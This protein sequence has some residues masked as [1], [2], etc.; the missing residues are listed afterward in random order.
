[1]EIDKAI[2]GRRSIRGY[3]DRDIP[4]SAMTEWLSVAIYAPSSMNGQPWCFIVVRAEKKK[5]HLVEIK[6]PYCA[7]EKQ[8]DRRP[9]FLRKAAVGIVVYMDK[10]KSHD[11]ETENGVLATAHLM[12]GTD[13]RGL[14][15]V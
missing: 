14:G 7:A 3:Q 11:R 4:D 9:D 6:N 12:L 2:K 8:D 5:E 13:N 15:S 1:M 10:E